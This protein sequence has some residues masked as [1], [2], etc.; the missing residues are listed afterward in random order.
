[1]LSAHLSAVSFTI[2][3]VYAY[4]DIWPLMT[5]TLQPKDMAEGSILWVKLA[6]LAFFGVVE[7]IT[8]P[9]PYI[10]YDPAVSVTTKLLLRIMLTEARL[11]HPSENPSPEQTASIAS[12]C[13]YV[14]IEP[15]IWRAYR[16]PHLPASEIPPLCDYDE[17]THLIKRGYPVG[18]SQLYYVPRN[19]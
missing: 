12:F 1:M 16:V 6:L 15:T 18:S 2:L 19:C 13:T 7:P 4:R 17:T 11:K 8:E 3:L 9:Y 14:W 10:P 5:F